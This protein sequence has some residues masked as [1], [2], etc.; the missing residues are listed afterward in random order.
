MPCFNQV[1]YSHSLRHIKK[2]ATNIL[3]KYSTA[4]ELP[5]PSYPVHGTWLYILCVIINDFHNLWHE[6][7]NNSLLLILSEIHMIK[8]NKMKNFQHVTNNSDVYLVGNSQICG[9]SR[10]IFW[11]EDEP[12]LQQSSRHPWLSGRV[13]SAIQ[14]N[15]R[16]GT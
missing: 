2:Q 12:H 8:D 16:K 11:T 15:A 9:V 7:F 6:Q 3:W 1:S 5:Y 14:G 4:T 13:C 10:W